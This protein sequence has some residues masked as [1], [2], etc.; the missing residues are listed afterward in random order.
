MHSLK[1]KFKKNLFLQLIPDYRLRPIIRVF[2]KPFIYSCPPAFYESVLVPVLAH[3]STHS[4]Y[5]CNKFMF[6]L[7]FYIFHDVKQI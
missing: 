7:L 2:M 6:I 3:V 1:Q 5:H 4:E